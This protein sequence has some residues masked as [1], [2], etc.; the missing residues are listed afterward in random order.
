[1]IPAIQGSIWKYRRKARL[2][3][4]MVPKKGGIL[5]G[6]RERKSSFITALQ[7]CKTLDKR[8]SDLLPGLHQLIARLSN[9]TRI[10]QIEA[11]AG[12]DRVALVFRHLSAFSSEDISCLCGYAEAAQIDLYLQAGGLDTVVPLS[13][14]SPRLLRYRLA[15]FDLEL[16][17]SPTDFT[18]VNAEI[19]QRMVN[20]VVDYLKP[21]ST[22]HILDLFCGLGNFTLPL[23]KSGA[24]VVGVEGEASLVRRGQENAKLNRMEN[25]WFQSA[26][27]HSQLSDGDYSFGKF[28]KL[29]FNKM[30]LDPSRSGAMEVVS[31]LIPKI[32]PELLVY[33]SCNPA[34]L[35]RDADIMV[36][37]NGYTLTDAGVIDMFPHTAHV[38][39][40]AVFRL[41]K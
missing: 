23:G 13:P 26:D 25:V 16:A 3:V 27:L 32:K 9:N 21:I 36:N 14:E 34:T 19:N 31:G 28:D 15:E 29:G 22:D 1:M 4:K 7:S 30:L 6:F 2:G 40:M 8:I 33:I 38:E 12:D 41:P 18:Q 24:H 5:I 35:A 20:Q 17:F 10:P 11:A 37:T 39:S